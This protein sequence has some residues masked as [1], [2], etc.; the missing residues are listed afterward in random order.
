MMHMHNTMEEFINSHSRNYLEMA[1]RWERRARVEAPDAYGK[2]TGVCGDTIEFFLTIV[3]EKI[4][5]TMFDTDG[6]MNTSACANTVS[7][8]SEGK[9]VTE[10]WEIKVEDIIEYLES[11]PPGEHHCAELAIGAFYLALGNYEEL[12]RSPWKKAYGS[13]QR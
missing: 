7:V 10:A 11:L 8:L 5:R 12:K 13:P 1:F 2:R 4:S 9:T 3:N 6:C